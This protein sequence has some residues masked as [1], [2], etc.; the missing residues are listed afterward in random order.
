M[1]NFEN[2]SSTSIL[3]IALQHMSM[4]RYGANVK[5]H[6]V[7][8]ADFQ[9]RRRLFWNGYVLD[10]DHSLRLGKPTSISPDVHVDLPEPLPSDGIGVRNVDGVDYHFLR[11]QVLLAKIQGKMYDRLYSDKSQRQTAEQ[12]YA[13]IDELDDDLQC[14]KENSPDVLKPL[15]PLD[16]SNYENLIFLTVLHYT[17]FQ[18]I[19]A[20]HSVVFH[21]FGAHNAND[22]D[23]RIIGS[24]ALCVGAARASIALLNYHDNSH[25][26]TRYALLAS[27]E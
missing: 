1:F 14:W 20:V 7:S 27:S 21:G 18:L 10:M 6:G 23:E 19:I 25:P 8:E 24:V 22:R 17:Y 2:Q 16:R 15:T 11:E 9:C 4:A 5:P 13:T 26:F 3:S 12:L